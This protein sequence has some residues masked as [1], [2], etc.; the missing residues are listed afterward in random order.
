MVLVNFKALKE[1]AVLYPVLLPVYACFET[2]G[3]YQNRFFGLCH[4][5][6]SKHGYK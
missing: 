4:A 5:I 1:P 3:I 2:V 6:F